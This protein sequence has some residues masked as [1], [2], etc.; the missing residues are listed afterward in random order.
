MNKS[1][2][3]N[4]ILTT[5]LLSTMG[6][7]TVSAT[8]SETAFKVAVVK[9]A[10]GTVDLTKGEIAT[11]I[12]KLTANK[13]KKEFYANKM[14]LCVAYLHSDDNAKSESAC[15]SAIKSLESMPKSKDRV[16]YLTA[17]NY[18]NRGVAR[19]K[20]KQLTAALSDFEA[21]FAIDNNPITSSNLVNM[22]QQ[23]PA[24]NDESVAELSD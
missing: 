12:Q 8:S 24:S 22:R 5:L 11:S 14:N 2:F 13:M 18:S 1:L 10:V 19:F 4:T 17:L 23:F 3:K 20:Q 16:K 9:G 7:A 21:A 15:T 6:S